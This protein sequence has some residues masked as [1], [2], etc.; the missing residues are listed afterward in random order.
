MMDS[1]HSS[2]R[3]NNLTRPDF[4]ATAAAST[5]LPIVN[6]LYAFAA[7]AKST[8]KV[9]LKSTSGRVR[10]VPEPYNETDVWWYNNTVPGPEIRFAFLIPVSIFLAIYHDSTGGVASRLNVLG[11]PATFLVNRKG[12]GIGYVVGPIEWDSPKIV[13]GIKSHLSRDKKENVL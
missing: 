5:I 10:L 9:S 13:N 3:R 7:Q 12:K 4:I 1:P 6:L 11:I 8:V 2:R